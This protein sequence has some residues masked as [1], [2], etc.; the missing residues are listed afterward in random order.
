MW[1]HLSA[2]PS[3]RDHSSYCQP[4]V[5]R[6]KKKH[7]SVVCL[8]RYEHDEFMDLLNTLEY[9]Y[10]DRWQPWCISICAHCLC[11][12]RPRLSV[13]V[14]M[15]C[16]V[17]CCHD[18]AHLKIR[19]NTFPESVRTVNGLFINWRTN[20][21]KHTHYANAPIFSWLLRRFIFYL[22]TLCLWWWVCVISII[23]APH[24]AVFA[25]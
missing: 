16:I 2:F 14:P 11:T 21:H 22:C 3:D 19:I 6:H 8:F 4:R 24:D 25:S 23:L 5:T 10:I 20:S 7:A 13:F 18:N 1:C 9:V 15:M 17:F 12:L